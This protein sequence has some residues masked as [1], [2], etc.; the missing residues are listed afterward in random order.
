MILTVDTFKDKF[1][2]DGY[3][4]WKA[5]EGKSTSKSPFAQNGNLENLDESWQHLE[6]TVFGACDGGTVTI[7]TKSSWHAKDSLI[8]TVTWGNSTSAIGGVHPSG[9]M[10]MMGGGIA[11]L[12]QIMG[13]AQELVKQ[14]I[15][16]LIE[17][18]QQKFEI[19]RLKDKIA[20]MEDAEGPT[21][22]DM[23]IEGITSRLPE[24]IDSFL[25]RR[26]SA[27][28]IGVLGQKAEKPVES[29][30]D[31]ES[32]PPLKERRAMDL[33][34]VVNAAQVLQNVF[35]EYNV[36]DLMYN[37]AKYCQANPSQAQ[38]VI[39]MVMNQ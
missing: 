6:D 13:F 33:N 29:D 22:K 28:A 38:M 27:P 20:Q 7:L 32:N 11:G 12:Q 10:P 8:V 21:T 18:M 5:Y 26:A 15:T 31:D 9:Q 4:Y 2:K 24:L 37:L 35:P 39:K 14:Q 34:A 17:G 16:P 1:F 25:G 23:V 19:E 30:D 36:S 3:P